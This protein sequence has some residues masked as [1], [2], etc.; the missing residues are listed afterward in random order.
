MSRTVA[1][2]IAGII[3]GTVAALATSWLWTRHTSGAQ[4]PQALSQPAPQRTPEQQRA[5]ALGERDAALLA[6]S[7]ETT[8]PAW[9]GRSAAAF[10]A[11]YS[12]GDHKYR[13]GTVDCR[14][15]S[16]LVELFWS[17]YRDASADSKT[18]LR[19]S[20]TAIQKGAPNCAFLLFLLPPEDPS[21]PYATKLIHN[22]C[23][24]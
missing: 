2:I 20:E 4:A 16:C 22:A 8:D 15:S 12:A 11:V 17:S 14:S 13:L 3:G 23:P 6:H 21:L 24:R 1:V 19:L 10:E 7:R 5:A 18:I 9:A